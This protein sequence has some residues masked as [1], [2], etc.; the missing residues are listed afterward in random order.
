MRK[1]LLGC[2]ATLTGMIGYAGLDAAHAQTAATNLSPGQVSVRLNGRVNWYAGIES[3]SIDSNSS[4]GQ[5]TSTDSFLG[6]MRLYPG[7]DGVAANGLHYGAAAEIRMNSGQSASD[8][9]LYVFQAY[10]YLGLPQLGQVSFGQQN[11]PSVLFETGFFEGFNDGGWNGDIE[12]MVPAAANPVYPFPDSGSAYDQA[13]DKIVYLSPTISGF[14]LALGFTPNQTASNYAPAVTSSATPI[15][16][17]M[18]R[19]MLDIGGQYTGKFGPLGVQVGLDYTT[20]GQVANTG[21]PEGVTGYKN[22]SIF[23]GGAT[24]TYGGL[25]IGGNAVTGAFNMADGFTF[26]LEPD[27]GSKATGFLAGA[28]YTMGPVVF[29]GSFFRFNQTGDL[30]GGIDTGSGATI[31]SAGLTTGQQQNDGVA[32]GLT[33]TLVPGVNLF[34]DYLYGIRQQGGYNFETGNAGTE[35]NQIQ[36][37]LF[38]V[39]TQIQW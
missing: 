28:Q 35:H 1:L 27:G 22:M 17:G 23:T 10:G 34:A 37:Q 4:T 14:Q 31:T 9:T 7:F 8:E 15:S 25:T 11:G 16:G 18:P 2:A 36:S 32:A 33:Y 38:G 39:G 20:A 29:G 19:N 21:D 6:Y 12:G 30:P 13:S 5:K 24:V 3:S 26:Q